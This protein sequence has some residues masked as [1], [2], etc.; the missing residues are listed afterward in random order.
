ME[1][2]G[3]VDLVKTGPD[4]EIFGNIDVV[5]GYYIFYGR[6]LKIDEGEIIFQGGEDFDPTMNIKAEYTYRDSEKVKRVL[7]LSITGLLSDPKISFTL[8]D[9]YLSEGDAVSILVFGRTSD[10][11]SSSG[12]SGLVSAAGSKMIAKVLTSQL[13]KTLGARFNLDMIEINATENWQSAAF[14]VGKYITNNLFV[15]YQRGFGETD[16]EEITPETV[17]LEYELNRIFFL[18]LQ[19]GSSKTSGLDIILKLEEKRKE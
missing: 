1:L 6:R 15:T 3:D 19:S 12:Q 13:S 11:M 8:D 18:H 2:R 4:F 16:G 7:G 14:V 17:T 10:E 9:N 5:R